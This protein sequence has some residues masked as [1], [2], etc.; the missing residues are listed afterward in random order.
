MDQ[1]Q[2]NDIVERLRE[3]ASL[4]PSGLMDEAADEIERLRAENKRLQAALIKAAEM[5][6]YDRHR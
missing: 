2:D 5:V 4:T 1:P 6:T 3:R